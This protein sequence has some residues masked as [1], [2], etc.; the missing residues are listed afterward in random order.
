MCVCVFPFLDCGEAWT[1][2]G[3][4]TVTRRVDV[5]KDYVLDPAEDAASIEVRAVLANGFAILA[6]TLAQFLIVFCVPR[7]DGARR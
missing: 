4:L 6:F 5:G 7:R 2:A 3:A 1:T